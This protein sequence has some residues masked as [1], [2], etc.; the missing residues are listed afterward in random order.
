MLERWGRNG[1]LNNL[2]PPACIPAAP[3][4][5]FMRDASHLPCLIVPTYSLHCGNL[6]SKA[7]EC[8][9]GCGWFTALRNIRY[10]VQQDMDG[11]GFCCKSVRNSL[12]QSSATHHLCQHAATTLI[13]ALC[14]SKQA[15]PFKGCFPS[16]ARLSLPF[17]KTLSG[18]GDSAH[19]LQ[20]HLLCG[21][22]LLPL[23]LPVSIQALNQA[24]QSAA[25]Q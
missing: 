4:I 5:A 14:L 8:H 9:F 22:L 3:P 17:V 6:Y 15:L 11:A 19:T 21:F 25:L 1:G 10:E 12:W 18:C 16:Y 24:M 13:R 20:I 2:R 7:W 23:H